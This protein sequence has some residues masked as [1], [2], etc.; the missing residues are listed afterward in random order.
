MSDPQ[1]VEHFLKARVTKSY[2]EREQKQRLEAG[3]TACEV[4]ETDKEW[5]MTTQ[6]PSF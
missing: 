3:A 6:W 1:D 2:V 5:I 4:I